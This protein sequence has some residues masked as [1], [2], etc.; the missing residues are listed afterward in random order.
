M[1][2][3]QHGTAIAKAQQLLSLT[4]LS[5]HRVEQQADLTDCTVERSPQL[6]ATAKGIAW[7]AAGRP[8]DWVVPGTIARFEPRPDTGRCE[9]FMVFQEVLHAML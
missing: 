8:S 4:R 3:D 9:R 7:L 2:F 5:R 6:E 1:V